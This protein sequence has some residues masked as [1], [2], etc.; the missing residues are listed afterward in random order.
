[1]TRQRPVPELEF[2]PT[3]GDRPATQQSVA[4]PESRWSLVNEFLHTKTMA[5]NTHRAYAR[6]LR[7]FVDWTSK[8]WTQVQTKDIARYK[9]YLLN[10]THN[11]AQPQLSPASV[12]RALTALKS[13][14]KWLQEQGYISDN[15]AIQVPTPP[16]PKPEAKHLTDEEVL[17]L[18][19][20]LQHRGDTRLRDTAILVVLDHGLRADEVSQLNVGDYDGQRL[21][22][23]KAKHNSTGFVPLS[24]RASQAI[25]FYL[26]ERRNQGEMLEAQSPL[27][28]S[29][30]YRS[31]LRGKRLGYQ[32]IYMM[33]KDLAE[34]AGV[35]DCYPHRL[36]HTYAT[37]LVLLG[38]DSYLAR[39]LTRHE[40]E[41]SFR[42][43]SE[44]ARA[45]AAEQA[46]RQAIAKQDVQRPD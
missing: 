39:K 16:L 5:R 32:G 22:I 33:I 34:I 36:R 40:S 31:D 9:T 26:V 44:E 24:E 1:M 15:P 46:Y 37:R 45:I 11:E 14:F 2:F 38:I 41:Q 21:K 27:F 7:R 12:S 25:D 8:P 42:R 6:E 20:A 19:E 17:A 18:Y 29:Q 13:F 3:S 23:R 4:S 28:L 10:P 30:S 43:Y 35:K